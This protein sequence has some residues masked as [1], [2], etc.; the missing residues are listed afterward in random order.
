MRIAYVSVDEVNQSL[1]ARMAASLGSILSGFDP[2]DGCPLAGFD[3]VLYDLDRV[4]P[5]RRAALLR[6]VRSQREPFPKAVH[7]YSLTEEEA[8]ELGLR[9]VAVAQRLNLRFLRSVCATALRGLVSVPPDDAMSDS[10]WITLQD[11]P[12]SHARN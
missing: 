7:G 5:E 9:G 1:A 10:T 2:E 11:S 3:A 4:A 12:R 6:E 8:R